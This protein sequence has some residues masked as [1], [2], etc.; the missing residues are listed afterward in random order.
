[1]RTDAT[2][3]LQDFKSADLGKRRDAVYACRGTG[4]SKLLEGL[5]SVLKSDEHCNIRGF[6]AEVLSE[7]G[8]RY[9][10]P[11]II[12][13]LE[14]NESPGSEEWFYAALGRMR[15]PRGFDT[16]MKGLDG[17]RPADA[18][19]GLGLYGDPRAFDTITRLIGPAYVET[20]SMSQ[21]QILDALMLLDRERA[22]ELCLNL[23]AVG[24]GD[25]PIGSTLVNGVPERVRGAME[26]YLD[27]GNEDH[28]SEAVRILDK[29]G[30]AHSMERLIHYIK[31]KGGARW[32]AAS[33]LADHGV[34]AAGPVLLLELPYETGELERRF[35]V[36]A[37]GILKT[38]DSARGICNYLR[39]EVSA[40]GQVE[41]M[42]A[43]ANLGDRRAISTIMSRASDRTS[44][45]IPRSGDPY[46]RFPFN[47]NVADA[48]AW[49]TA[50]LRDGKKPFDEDTLSIQIETGQDSLVKPNTKQV[51]TWWDG[52]VDRRIYQ[53]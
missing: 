46:Q 30:D 49:A 18:A 14:R 25:W 24:P 39:V 2:K 22:T 3:I 29:L 11:I 35:F 44:E 4:D 34:S 6:A 13:Q 15:D 37:L 26:E 45:E 47:I 50:T 21:S 36:A 9:A 23:F 20:G 38:P 5:R 17:R 48:A 40:L 16:L 32:S 53:F 7:L 52:L 27:Y 33:V 28:Q 51:A 42:R 8:D 1:M 10:I 19:A 31:G 41:M 43:L 12:Y